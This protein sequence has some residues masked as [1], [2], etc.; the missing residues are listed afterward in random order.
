MSYDI[1]FKT[2]INGKPTY[3]VEKIWAIV[4][5]RFSE[6]TIHGKRYLM[7]SEYFECLDRGFQN[8]LPFKPKLHTFRKDKNNRWYA[9]M[10]I[11]FLSMLE[12]RYVSLCT[13]S[14]CS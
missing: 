2:E 8:M 7:P 11:D 4:Q 1:R 9:G 6:T 13:S 14:A 12:K 10:M 5:F 3:F